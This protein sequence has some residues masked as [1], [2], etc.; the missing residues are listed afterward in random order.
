MS[1]TIRC[2]ACGM[3]LYWGE[4]IKRRLYMRAVPSE[5]S[6]LHQYGDRC[7]CCEAE[8]AIETVR[9]EMEGRTHVAR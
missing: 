6:V 8:L 3:L 2:R 1:E 7:P 5:E 4:P 9:I